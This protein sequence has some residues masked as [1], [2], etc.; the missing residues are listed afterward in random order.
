MARH[1]AA[2]PGLPGSHFRLEGMMGSM[3][4]LGLDEPGPLAAGTLDGR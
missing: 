4:S 2:V 3:A 1:V